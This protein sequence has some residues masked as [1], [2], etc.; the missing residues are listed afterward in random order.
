MHL[1][2]EEKASW[3]RCPAGYKVNNDKDKEHFEEK[4]GTH[5]KLCKGSLVYSATTTS[6]AEAAAITRASMQEQDPGSTRCN[7]PIKQ[8]RKVAGP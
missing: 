8:G 5:L 7:N 2:E 4:E 1:R 6:T 3:G